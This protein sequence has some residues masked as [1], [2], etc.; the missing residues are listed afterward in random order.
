MLE[1]INEYVIV[2]GEAENAELNAV[3]AQRLADAIGLVCLSDA[4]AE[5]QCEILVGA[6]CRKESKDAISALDL[7][8]YTLEFANGKLI[9]AGAG[10][11]STELAVDEAISFFAEN[12][13]L[14]ALSFGKRDVRPTFAECD[15]D[16]RI[17]EYNVLV[18]YPGWGCEKVHNPEVE[19]RKEIIAAMIRAAAPDAIVLCEMFENWSEQ[20]PSLLSPKYGCVAWKRTEDEYSN[21]TPIM[22]NTERFELL[23]GGY[24][25][26]AIL[27]TKNR[28]VVTYAVLRERQTGEKLIVFGTHFE[29]ILKDHTPAENEEAR[30]AQVALLKAVVDGVLERH[31]GAVAITGD[32]NTGPRKPDHRAYDTLLATLCDYENAVG[33]DPIV[34]LDQMFIGKN[35]EIVSSL[36][37]TSRWVP[38][39]SD[40]KPVICDIR[41]KE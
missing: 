21:R 2:Y 28:R 36:I 30:M 35:S 22:Y 4:S 29:S 6:T 5:A 14:A 10:L 12:G 27:K 3:L 24:E 23:E 1:N 7:M 31:T 25:N 8:E 37:D 34:S 15:G 17:M 19:V 13:D 41:V 26:I 33:K 9:V 18:E 11:F 32:F 38:F 16:Y 20:L 40:H 39:A